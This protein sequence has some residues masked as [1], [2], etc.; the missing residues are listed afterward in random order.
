M[1]GLYQALFWAI[2]ILK[3]QKDN[4]SPRPRGTYIPVGNPH[5]HMDNSRRWNVLVEKQEIRYK[6]TRREEGLYWW[7]C[8]QESPSKDAFDQRFECWGDNRSE[9]RF[10]A[11][12]NSGCRG[13]DS[14]LHLASS[15]AG[16][17]QSACAAWWRRG[18]AGSRSAGMWTPKPMVLTAV[19]CSLVPRRDDTGEPEM[20]VWRER[21][22]A[23]SSSSSGE[24]QLP[25]QEC[26]GG[27]RIGWEQIL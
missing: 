3:G 7:E 25:N 8:G 26:N 18:V 21:S 14:G 2:G 12:G 4:Q 10:P 27:K 24:T 9:R 6:E 20:D 5:K 22:Q 13:L 19:L 17:G 1:L 23:L 16:E 11:K 15:R